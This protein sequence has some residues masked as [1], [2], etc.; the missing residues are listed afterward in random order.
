MGTYFAVDFDIFEGAAV[1]L[2][3]AVAGI[4]ASVMVS[5]F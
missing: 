1:Y 5:I 4:D 2:V 3:N